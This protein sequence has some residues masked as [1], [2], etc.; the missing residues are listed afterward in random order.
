MRIQTF[1]ETVPAY[2]LLYLAYG[3]AEGISEDE[4]AAID[5]YLSDWQDEADNCGASRYG[6][7]LYPEDE[8]TGEPA[9]PYFSNANDVTNE[10][11]D[12]QPVDV[13]LFYNDPDDA[14]L[15]RQF[16]ELLEEIYPNGIPEDG[17][18]LRET[19][20]NWTDALCKDGQ[21]SDYTYNE[22]QYAGKYLSIYNEG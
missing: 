10:G 22:C 16:D 17:P 13:V 9:E 1:R 3:E 6:L 11:G 4:Q 2:A 18:M 14:E 5:M 12:V 19:F 7:D 15:S 20:N 8:D 21:I